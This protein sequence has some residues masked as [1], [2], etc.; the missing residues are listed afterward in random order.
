[1]RY[2]LDTNVCIYI[3][4]QK[5]PQIRHKFESHPITDF[6]L[7]SITLAELQYGVAKS[8]DKVKNQ[9]AL[10]LFITPFTLLDFDYAATLAYGNLRAALETGGSPIGAMDLLI[11]AHA[12]S[13]NLT[14]VTHNVREF[15]RVAG[16]GVETWFSL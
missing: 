5:P 8:S 3:I 4:R 11:A 15:G 13:R 6:A 2:M 1:M 10:D 12:L 16:L 14:L 9:Q 7:S